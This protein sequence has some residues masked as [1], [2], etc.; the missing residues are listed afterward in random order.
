[1]E[2][3]SELQAVSFQYHSLLF[4]ASCY[5]VDMWLEDCC[6]QLCGMAPS[7]VLVSPLQEQISEAQQFQRTIESYHPTMDSLAALVITDQSALGEGEPDQSPASKNEAKTEMSVLW[8]RYNSLKALEEARLN[9]FVGFL[10]TV[11][12]YESSQDAWATLLQGWEEKASLLP[13][14]GGRPETVQEQIEEIKVGSFVPRP[15]PPSV[16][17]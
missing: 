14:P 10:P 1:M 7:G 16:W 9:L 11:Q 13:P 8:S 3:N 17:E 5:P 6:Q 12:Q 2:L 15:I 4:Q